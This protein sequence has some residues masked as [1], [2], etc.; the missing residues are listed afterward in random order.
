MEML[1][2]AIHENKEWKGFKLRGSQM[3]I[4]HLM[5]ADDLILYGE[6][7]LST[8]SA[9]VKTLEHFFKNSGQK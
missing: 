7:T 1:S 6:A 2:K 5:F 3:E 9:V 4:T 8:L